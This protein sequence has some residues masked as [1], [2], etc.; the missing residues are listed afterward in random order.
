ML[1]PQQGGLAGDPFSV[2]VFRN[3]CRRVVEE[4]EE[5][6]VDLLFFVSQGSGAGRVTSGLLEVCVCVR[7]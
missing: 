1:L 2:K 3:S 5:E 6:V 7:R 4:W